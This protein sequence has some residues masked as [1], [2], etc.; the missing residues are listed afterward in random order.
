MSEGSVPLAMEIARL[1]AINSALR[2][3]YAALASEWGRQVKKVS[4]VLADQLPPKVK[5]HAE[6]AEWKKLQDAEVDAMVAEIIHGVE[7]YR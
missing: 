3:R 7:D 1:A 6:F 2:L 4:E 5:A